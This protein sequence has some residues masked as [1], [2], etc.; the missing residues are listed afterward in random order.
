ML[1][2]YIGGCRTDVGDTRGVHGDNDR[3]AGQEL[4]DFAQLFVAGF[5]AGDDQLG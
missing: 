3:G 1:R 4:L 2:H 5:F